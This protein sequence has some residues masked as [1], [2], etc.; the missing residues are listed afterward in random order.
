M[1]GASDLGRQRKTNQ[2]SLFYDEVQ[3]FAV[4]AD[5]IGG[6]KGGETASGL[7][8]SGLKSAFM[9]SDKIKHDEIRPFLTAAIDRIN[10][11]I[12]EKGNADE[13][14]SGMGT[15]MDCLMFVGDKLHVA[16]IGDSRTYL[17]YDKHLWQLTL[18]HNVQNFVERGWLPQTSIQAGAKKTALTR[19]MG[20]SDHLDVDLYRIKLKKGQ[21]FLTCSDGLTGMVDDLTIA[22]TLN[23][24]FPERFDKLTDLLITKANKNG[25]RDNITVLLSYVEKE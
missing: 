18:D 1:V 9:E 12:I 16:H 23:R 10:R 5:G 17:Y 3:G 22:A 24:H 13:S 15:T 2:D 20:L 21:L 7:V 6:R 19:A 11:N 4:V 8:V 25:G 14:L